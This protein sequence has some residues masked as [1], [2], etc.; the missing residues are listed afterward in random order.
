MYGG[1]AFGTAGAVIVKSDLAQGAD[2][3]L[4]E[5]LQRGKIV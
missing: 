3:G 1:N 5:F 2:G 4:E